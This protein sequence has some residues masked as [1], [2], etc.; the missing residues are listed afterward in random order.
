MNNYKTIFFVV[1]VLLIFPLP[2]IAVDLYL[3]SLPSM[4]M[5]FKTTNSYSLLTLNVYILS[6]G[7]AQLIYGPC[8][9][10]FGRRPPLLVGIA[11][12]FI[13]SVGCVLSGSIG[14][15]ITFRI[16]QGLGM[17]C[18]LVIASAI[19]GESFTGKKLAKMTAWSSAI[20]SLSVLLAPLLG[21]Y[22][23]SIS[24]WRT[25]FIFITVSSVFVFLTTIFF[26]PE[27]NS[28]KSFIM[29][30][31][32]IIS[33]YA[34]IIHNLK[35]ISYVICSL[36]GYSLGI[37]FNVVGPFLLQNVLHVSVVHTGIMLFFTGL[38]YLGGTLTNNKI[39]NFI[40]VN[41]AILL[42]II[43]MLISAILLFC[44]GLIGWF[45]SFSV[46]LFTCLSIF[47]VG[48]IFPNCF[49]KGLEIFPEKLG[50]SSAIIS[51]V[52]LIGVA[53]VGGIVS[54]ITTYNATLLGIFFIFEAMGCLA[55]YLLMQ[56][57]CKQS[58]N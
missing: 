25:N 29:D 26:I 28:N 2:Q 27:T 21:G 55:S 12:F 3:P 58:A 24:G 31:K 39:L 6:L 15:L 5:Y 44:V 1:A 42:G 8:S 4:V 30:I 37:T 49:A 52:G 7:I 38:A 14:Q 47:G 34:S 23:Q 22:F 40:S 10:R 54:H 45:T 53:L 11:I 56:F 17:G 20:F 13:G 19:L 33:N 41:A 35:F 32:K 48:F 46:M 57:S 43:I 18:G 36:F 51:S 16:I 50:A 9:D